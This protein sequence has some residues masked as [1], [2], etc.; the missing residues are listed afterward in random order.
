MSDMYNPNGAGFHNK[1][2]MKGIDRLN[3]FDSIEDIHRYRIDLTYGTYYP[4]KCTPS[5]SVDTDSEYPVLMP[6]G[7]IISLAD[8][9]PANAYSTN[10]TVA[11]ILTSGQVAVS[12][13][14]SDGSV[15]TKSI[16]FLYGK[17]VAGFFVKANG[18]NEATDTYQTADV[19]CGILTI[20]GATPTAG[21]TTY[22]RT[23]NKPFGIVGSRVVGDL[24]Y[25]Y[26][27]YEFE[28]KGYSI[29]PAGVITLPVVMVYG[30]GNTGTVMTAIQSAVDA[31]H[32]YIMLSGTVEATVLAK[33]ASGLK[34][35]PNLQ[36]KFVEYDSVDADQCF[37][38]VLEKRVRM[39]FGM[40]EYEDSF[41]GSQIRG[42][43]TGGLSKRMYTFISSCLTAASVDSSLC[44]KDLM[45][46]YLYS[47]V[48]TGT[49]NVKISFSNVD[50]AFG[51][52]AK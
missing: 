39:P 19:T 33:P 35:M 30:S 10:D 2:P 7:T 26:L 3:Q 4:P 37:G 46:T 25:R 11:G 38:K 32:Q 43:D 8:I 22:V 50:V 27:N 20:A 17:D 42:T 52:L 24:R 1:L 23:A 44:T 15:M 6:A 34:L 9:K 49:S 40:S 31:K 13:N 47:G 51:Y 14:V 21:A 5:V 48:A 36:G 12:Q 29:I 16:D 28:A 18:G 41:P 45:K